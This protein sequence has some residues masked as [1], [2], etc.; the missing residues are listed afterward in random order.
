MASSG[1]KDQITRR[2]GNI[3]CQARSL[4]PER[5]FD[6]LNHQILALANQLGNITYLKLLFFVLGY[7]FRVRHNIG[8]MQEGRLLQAD[9]NKRRLHTRQYPAHPAFIDIAN[10]T[11]F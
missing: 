11:A 1:H 3:G 9:I 5:I 7:T 8:R 4:G 6:H 10:N 2:Q